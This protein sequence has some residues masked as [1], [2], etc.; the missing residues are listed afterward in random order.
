VSKAHEL[1]FSAAKLS[2][3]VMNRRAPGR[4]VACWYRRA[5]KGCRGAGTARK[6]GS[7]FAAGGRRA[8]CGSRWLGL[9]A[10]LLQPQ[11]GERQPGMPEQHPRPGVSHHLLNR[12]A[13]I[14]TVAV[15]RALP[16]A[17]LVVPERALLETSAGVCREIRAV[18][19]QC[20]TSAVHLVAVDAEHGLDRSSL[21]EE[22][23]PAS[24]ARCRSPRL[25]GGAHLSFSHTRLAG[26]GPPFPQ[27]PEPIQDRHGSLLKTESAPAPGAPP[28]RGAFRERP[29]P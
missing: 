22:T 7:G 21:T 18:A 29:L 3:Y 17:G 9:G 5:E 13:A 26:S 25:T 10:A 12:A 20:A 28:A 8:P 16:A 19:T 11:V 1:S 23:A 6:P 27:R 24:C 4:R 14:R 15:D 2:F